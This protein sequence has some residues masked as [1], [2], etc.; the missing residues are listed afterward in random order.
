MP[1]GIITQMLQLHAC[2]TWHLYEGKLL[3]KCC[4]LPTLPKESIA[5]SGNKNYREMAIKNKHPQTKN[6][7]WQMLMFRCFWKSPP[8]APNNP[9][10]YNM[11]AWNLRSSSQSLCSVIKWDLIWENV[12]EDLPHWVLAIGNIILLL[13]AIWNHCLISVPHWLEK[14][15][16]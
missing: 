7:S 4:P 12:L 11:E 16:W 15:Q 2:V 9:L 13:S 6:I 3:H 1:P 14:D 5:T 10:N 8:H